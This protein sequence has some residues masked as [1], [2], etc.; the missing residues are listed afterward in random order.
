MKKSKYNFLTDRQNQSVLYN[1]YTDELCILEPRLKELY[2]ENEGEGIQ[3]IHPTFYD[4][5]IEKGFLIDP[6]IDEAKRQIT[7]WENSDTSEDI[8]QITVNPTLNCNMRCWYCYEEHLAKANM[9]EGVFASIVKLI[10]NKVKNPQLKHI[11]LSFFGGEPLL[12]FSNIVLPLLKAADEL[13][14]TNGKLLFTSFV[15]NGYLL[16]EQVLNDL[17]GISI[18]HPV[19]FQ[20]TLDGNEEHHDMTRHTAQGEG[21]YRR[22][23]KH[24]KGAIRQGFPI[25]LRLNYT[26]KNILSFV[27]ILSDLQDITAEER[28]TLLYIDMHRVWQ[29]KTS[30][31]ERLESEEKTLR[32]TFKK[33]GFR[34]SEEKSIDKYRCY[35]DAENHVVV[36]YNGDLYRC[37]ARD[38]KPEIRE[39]ILTEDGILQWNE[40]SQK[41]SS[42][43][44]GNE[45]CRTC[46]IYPLCHGFCSQSKLESNDETG[47]YC[48][49]DDEKK[50]ELVE[51]R[52][53]VLLE[54]NSLIN[55]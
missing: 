48:H 31:F 34:V 35:A 32:E 22:I 4:Y 11:N 25:T 53:S 18:D 49:Y 12:S 46:R 17:K 42:I 14:H 13:C 52:I 44:F 38:F 55:Q 9:S 51:D 40:H 1:L 5:L 19:V 6:D 3:R 45:F 28:S 26:A 43:R 16:T 20:I 7:E 41:R 29:D 23:I 37:T 24:V 8:F 15:T 47:C 2:I 39:G 10:E 30:N 27:D 21:S 50:R 36:N 54:T 33:E